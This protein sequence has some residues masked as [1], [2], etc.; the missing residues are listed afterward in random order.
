MNDIS[1][2]ETAPCVIQVDIAG[3]P[4]EKILG[5]RAAN[6]NYIDRHAVRLIIIN[7]RTHEFVIISVQ[8]GNYYKLPG[9]GVE[10]DEDHRLAAAGEA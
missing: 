7:N 6:I 5:A 9:G 1:A 3:P 4:A 2:V 8:K 10:K